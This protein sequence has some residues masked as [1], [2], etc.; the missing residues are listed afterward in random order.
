MSPTNAP[1]PAQVSADLTEAI[2]AALNKHETSIVTKWVMVAETVDGN[3]D[4]GLWT[5]ASKG[6]AV[7]DEKGML[8]HAV[9]L[10]R[11]KTI[12]DQLERG[13]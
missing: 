1:D 8:H 2:T 13:V 12:R 4:I 6:L 7:W 9:D 10:T 11:A 3:G 5:C